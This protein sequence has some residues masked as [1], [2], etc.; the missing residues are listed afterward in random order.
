V[1]NDA[2]YG[3]SGLT[4]INNESAVPQNINGNVFGDTHQAACTLRVPAGLAAFYE[5]AKVLKRVPNR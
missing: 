5:N 2:F 4:S 1:G 3:C